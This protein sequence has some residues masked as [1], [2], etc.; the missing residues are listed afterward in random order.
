MSL[1]ALV[2]CRDVGKAEQSADGSRPAVTQ[3]V[4]GGSARRVSE[5]TTPDSA[6]IYFRRARVYM[7]EQTY[8][9]ALKEL[10]QAAR[11]DSN[12]AAIQDM[13]GLAYSFRLQP[14]KAIEHIHK[15]IDLDPDNGSFYMHLGKAHMLLTDYEGAKLAY[16]RAIELG[17]RRAKP[18]Y[19][20]GIISEQENRLADAARYF[21]KAIQ[22]LP[23]LPP[24]ISASESSWRGRVTGGGRRSSTQRRLRGIRT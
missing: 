9:R 11:L 20:L 16:G 10:Q 6:A 12:S 7:K 5:P 8:A 17:L 23:E 24:A 4:D 18:Y 22:V 2:Q 15:A 13:L 19:D 14:G 1:L 21:E 3:T